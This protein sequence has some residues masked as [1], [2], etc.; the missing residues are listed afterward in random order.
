MINNDV[1][2]SIRYMLD[3]SDQKLI[4]IMQLAAPT[5]A[6]D[7]ATLLAYLK[8]EGEPGFVECDS[9][10][11]AHFLDGLIFFRRGK[12][13]SRPARPVEKHVSNYVVLK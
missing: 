10:V 2:R 3:L 9:A 13:P 12:D 5:F 6:L 8:R 11:L 1:L 7:K 4:D